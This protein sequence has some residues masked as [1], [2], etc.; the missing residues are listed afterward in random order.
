MKSLDN[1][2]I[3]FDELGDWITYQN[4]KLN[5]D[6]LSIN[7]L[8]KAYEDNPKIID[9]LTYAYKTILFQSLIRNI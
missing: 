4:A 5:N 9:Y 1:K 8:I 2:I 7:I 3:S 6:E